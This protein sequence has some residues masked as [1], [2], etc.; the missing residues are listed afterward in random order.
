LPTFAG[1]SIAAFGLSSSLFALLLYLVIYLQDAKGYSAMGT[2][3]RLLVLSGGIML[4]AS[5]SGRLT[6]KIPIRLLIGPGLLL[7]SAS[8]FLMAGLNAHSSWTE[9]IPGFIVGGIGVGLV[10]PPLASTAVGV[11]EPRRAGMASGINSTFRQVGIATGVAALGSVFGSRLSHNLSHQLSSV[12]GFSGHTTQ[13]SSVVQSGGITKL[14]GS[15]PA[16]L[17][18]KVSAD[19]LGAFANALDFV[20]VIGGVVALVAGLASLALIRAKDFAQGSQSGGHTA[21]APVPAVGG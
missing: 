1:G 18:A 5:I 14:L 9:L 21:E 13:V 8:L 2:G 16:D 12:P 11:V 19:V 6:S 4:T 3:L 20:L 17:R 15:L 10:N 7:V